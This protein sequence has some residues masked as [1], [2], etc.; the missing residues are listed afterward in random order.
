MFLYTPVMNLT[1]CFC[2]SIV[3]LIDLFLNAN[4]HYI[5]L[6]SS[7]LF[8]HNWRVYFQNVLNPLLVLL[9]KTGFFDRIYTRVYGK[10]KFRKKKKCI[11]VSY[12]DLNFTL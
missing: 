5:T 8:F 2:C 6:H 11:C 10:T 3:Y 4:E 7:L 9:R 12:L 1:F